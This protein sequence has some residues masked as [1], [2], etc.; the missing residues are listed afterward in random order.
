MSSRM[1]MKETRPK[2]EREERREGEEDEWCSHTSTENVVELQGMQAFELLKKQAPNPPPR[3]TTSRTNRR[4]GG[5]VA[6][7][8]SQGRYKQGFGG[9]GVRDPPRAMVPTVGGDCIAVQGGGGIAGGSVPHR[10][11]PG[12]AMGMLLLSGGGG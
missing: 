3:P 5:L 11:L 4:G 9:G 7:R 10:M 8:A 12:G 6:H 2:R 1:M